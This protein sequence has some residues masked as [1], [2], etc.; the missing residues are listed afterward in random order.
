MD[1]KKITDE[2]MIVAIVVAGWLG[3]RTV[4]E[5]AR[6]TSPVSEHGRELKEEG[7]QCIIVFRPL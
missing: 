2:E 7:R 1:I 4:L 3:D 5:T 6:Q